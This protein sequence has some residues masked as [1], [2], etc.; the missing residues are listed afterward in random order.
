MKTILV[1]EN[2]EPNRDILMKILEIEGFCVV[3]AEDGLVGVQQV[4][5]HL[6]NLIVCD[7][8]MPG[9]DGYGVLDAVRRD[10][11]TAST[12]FVFVSAKAER[13]DVRRG[14]DLGADGYLT[15][16]F[17][18]AQLLRVVT[19]HLGEQAASPPP[20]SAVGLSVELHEGLSTLTH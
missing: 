14:I 3:G 19:S 5:T 1:I 9:L 11:Q 4:K 17:T 16:P 7:I 15:K 13:A 8:L 2:D 20:L 10:P 18:L 6:P 12:P